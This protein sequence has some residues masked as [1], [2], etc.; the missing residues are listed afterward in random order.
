[1]AKSTE[2]HMN[3]VLSFL[4]YLRGSSNLRIT[5]YKP[6]NAILLG[7][8]DADKSGDLNNCK[9]IGVSISSM[10]SSGAE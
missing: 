3:A 10:V 4:Q 7:E 9:S 5:Y 8:S 2:A 6:S 1:M